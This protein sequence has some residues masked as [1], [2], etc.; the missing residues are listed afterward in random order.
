MPELPELEVVCE[1]LNRRVASQVIERVEVLPPGGAIVVRDYTRQGLAAALEGHRFEAI[2]R[3]GQ[4][5]RFAVA[6]SPLWLVINPKLTGR[7]QLATPGDKRYAKTALVLTLAD[8][9]EL[10]Y[11]D[12]KTM[13]QVYLTARVEE[14]PGYAGMGPEALEISL[15]EFKERLRPFRGEIKGILVR[16]E[17]VAGIGNAY[18]DEILWAA[19]LHPYRKRTQLTVEEIERLYAAMRATLIDATD[20]MRVEMGEQIH[21]E[22]RT[23]LNVHL[24]TGEPCPRCGGQISLVSANQRITNFCRTCQPGG[25]FKGM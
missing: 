12:Q 4:F 10:R 25:L 8:G 5:L 22:P 11:V 20:K 14:V 6:K 18:A 24:R 7:L 17:F 15:A 21:R 1:V 13:G 23:F 19:R 3:R 9:Q 16:S 2:A